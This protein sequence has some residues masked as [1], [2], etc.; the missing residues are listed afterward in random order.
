MDL[1]QQRHLCDLQSYVGR[2]LSSL[3]KVSQLRIA[4]HVYMRGGRVAH[5]VHLTIA[6]SEGLL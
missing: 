5:R 1:L 2:V 3:A 6:G 4:T